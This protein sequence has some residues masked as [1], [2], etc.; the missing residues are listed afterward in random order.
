MKTYDKYIELSDK[1]IMWNLYNDK[2]SQETADILYNSLV[3]NAF[4]AF[5]EIYGTHFVQ[6]GRS[7]RHICVENTPKNRQNYCRMVKT[8][9][10]LQREIIN[11]FNSATE[12]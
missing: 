8:I 10:R 6:L 7:G 1:R 5:F 4:W 2:I 3:E 11:K 9:E 12:I